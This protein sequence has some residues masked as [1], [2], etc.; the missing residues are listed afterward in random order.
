MIRTKKKSM[1]RTKK[2][3]IQRNKKVAPTMT[4]ISK[5][6]NRPAL[7]HGGH[8][9]FMP[10]PPED[11]QARRLI[12][13]EENRIY[14]DCTS[15]I[16]CYKQRGCARLKEHQEE[17]AIYNSWCRENK[18]YL[19]KEADDRMTAFSAPNKKR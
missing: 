14:I 17:W 13:H 6:R 7:P 1:M 3:K 4:R 2:P 5:P 12:V 10:D 11:C 19:Q 9:G 15:C 18:A 16:G 8:G